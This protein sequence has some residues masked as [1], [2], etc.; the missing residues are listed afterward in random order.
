MAVKSSKVD[1]L[2]MQAVK[3]LTDLR[4][5]LHILCKDWICY[6]LDR[7]PRSVTIHGRVASVERAATCSRAKAS[8]SALKLSNFK[9]CTVHL[10]SQFLVVFKML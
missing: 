8:P 10:A 1:L 9:V 4:V 6:L 2:L 3:S 5:S 7:V